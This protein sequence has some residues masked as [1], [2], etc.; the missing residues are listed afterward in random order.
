MVVSL[1][2][3]ASMSSDE[4]ANSDWSAIGY[5]DGSR[6]Y[7]SARFTN[8]RKACA[9]HG[10]TA[11]FQAYQD[12]REQGLSEFCQPGRGFNVG[13]SGAS[14][15]GVC[16]TDLEPEFLEAYRVGYQLYDLRSNVSNV[17]SL[18]SRKKRELEKIT[19][20]IRFKEAALISAESTT[21]A[22]ILLLVDIKD[23][24]EHKGRV[25]AEIQGLIADRVRYQSEL[26]HYEQTVAAYGY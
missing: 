11:D 3:C 14:Y 7:T 22:R 2:G 24:A 26:R 19:K 6:G 25:E 8:R 15:N 21:E 12:G 17:S 16:A 10:V 9:S 20:E 5:E 18:I 13:A 1:S 4:C 23:L